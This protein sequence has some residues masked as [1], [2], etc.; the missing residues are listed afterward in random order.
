M[1]A[2][3]LRLEAEQAELELERE[4]LAATAST[5]SLTASLPASASSPAAAA[6]DEAVLPLLLRFRR[7]EGM[8][9]TPGGWGAAVGRWSCV[10]T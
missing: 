5:S 6:R 10:S 2:A 8:S 3:T 4:S 9:W 1:R 7:G